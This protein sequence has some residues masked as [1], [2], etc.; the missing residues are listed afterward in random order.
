MLP[1]LMAVL[2]LADD[3]P[4]ADVVIK[5]PIWTA[6]PSA[7]DYISAYPMAASTSGGALLECRVADA[8]LLEACHVVNQF[9]AAIGF[10]QAAL[11]LAPKF[12]V[13]P[14]SKSG[15]STK[16]Q[17]VWVQVIWNFMSG[18]T[19]QFQTMRLRPPPPGPGTLVSIISKPNWARAPTWAEMRPF[20]PAQA[21]K[22]GVSGSAVLV[23]GVFKTGAV[24][25]CIVQSESPAGYGF[26]EASVRAS[27]MFVMKP[28]TRDRVPV[29]DE[30]IKIPV[31]WTHPSGR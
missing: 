5:D 1:I 3:A 23:C 18:P 6:T 27:K 10:D 24:H 9:P 13:A 4:A 14:D 12:V 22:D 7:D 21:M 26:G 2:I 19:S 17:R 8:G 30:G 25:D 28:A 29:D 11:A 15:V 16:G 20:Y 31:A